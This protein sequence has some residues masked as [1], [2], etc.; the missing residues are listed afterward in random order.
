[1]ET[2]I[3]CNKCK[4][5]KLISE[6]VVEG[7]KQIRRVCIP[8]EKNRQRE[9]QRRAYLY[10]PERQKAISLKSYHKN[11]GHRRILAKARRDKVRND[12][13]L[14]YSNGKNECACCGETENCFLT[15]DHMHGGGTMERKKIGAGGHHLYRV[16][17][18]Q[19]YP[20]GFQI[21]CFNCNVGKFRFGICPHK[22]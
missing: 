5:P 15:L 7:K 8:C 9:K 20:S 11:G 13:I 10:S 2:K 6:L 21:L 17:R 14:H 22:K 18:K 4:K 1:M 12:I 19:G 3:I 16:I